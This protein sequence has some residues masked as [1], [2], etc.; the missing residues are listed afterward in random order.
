MPFKYYVYNDEELDRWV[1]LSGE[2]QQDLADF[3]ATA[4][5][6]PYRAVNGLLFAVGELSHA[7]DN[8]AKYEVHAMGDQGELLRFMRFD[9]GEVAEVRYVQEP[10]PL[11]EIGF[12]VPARV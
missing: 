5:A 2:V 9:D 3:D 11:D 4:R 7:P 8:P 10:P 12:H 6:Y 1:E